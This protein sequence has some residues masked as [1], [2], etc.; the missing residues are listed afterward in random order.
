MEAQKRTHS[1]SARPVRIVEKGFAANHLLTIA[2]VRQNQ[3]RGYKSPYYAFFSGAPAAK[4]GNG[5][6]YLRDQENAVVFKLE[7]S[8][9]DAVRFALLEHASGAGNNIAKSY[10]HWADPAKANSPDSKI[11]TGKNFSISS[12]ANAKSPGERIVAIAFSGGQEVGGSG[13]KAK[14]FQI[15]FHPFDAMAVA[16]AIQYMIAR[17]RELEVQEELLKFKDAM[18]DISSLPGNDV[19]DDDDFWRFQPGQDQ[20]ASGQ[21]FAGQ[22]Q[23]QPQQKQPAQQPQKGAAVFGPHPAAAEP[24]H[25]FRRNRDID[26]F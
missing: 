20:K 9:L 14:S 19:S 22:R 10:F 5:K 3:D 6:T 11:T 15:A 13:Q 18:S 1:C 7:L 8:K 23:T 25:Q 2:I 12:A 21:H 17:A 4:N 26:I 24:S 16:D